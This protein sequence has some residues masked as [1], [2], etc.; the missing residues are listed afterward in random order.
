MQLNGHVVWITGAARRLGRAMALDLARRGADLVV[1]YHHSRAEAEQV[2]GEIERLGRRVL[3][4]QADLRSVAAIR[5]CIDRIEHHFGRLD[6]L[7][8]NA[9]NFERVEFDRITEEDWDLSLDTN[10]KGPFFCARE[11]ARL[12]RRDGGGKIINLADWSA[13]R[14]YRHYAPY[15]IAKG[16]IVTMTQVLALELAPEV[17]VNAV[18]PGVVL[19][20][21]D[22]AAEAMDK[23]LRQVPLGRA[24]SPDDIVATVAFLLEGSDYI[25][26]Q[27]I[28][29]DGGR[30]IAQPPRPEHA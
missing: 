12:L 15:M 29:V 13:L 27:V 3:T 4:V 28:C 25:T 8:N 14:P 6:V 24:G 26:G 20:Q 17:Q 30:L 5:H 1:H 7:I 21:P 18:A 22:V 11:A 2:A 16:G 19:P 9:S 23:L 10:L